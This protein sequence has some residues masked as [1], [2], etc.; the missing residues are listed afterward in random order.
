VLSAESSLE[1]KRETERL[2]HEQ[3]AR[4]ARVWLSRAVWAAV[5]VVTS[6]VSLIVVSAL[7][8]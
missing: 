6:L 4:R 8:K 3:D 1:H 2:Q 7:P 5:L